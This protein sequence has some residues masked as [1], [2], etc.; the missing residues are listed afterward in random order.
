MSVA[1]RPMRSNFKIAASY[2]FLALLKFIY[3]VGGVQLKIY[4][5]LRISHQQLDLKTLQLLVIDKLFLS[6]ELKLNTNN[7][8]ILR[9]L[10]MNYGIT[11][12][13]MVKLIVLTTIQ[14]VSH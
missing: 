6:I 2:V 5:M 9:A 13:G 11:K 8:I 1:R 7:G 4:F 12:R 14:N 10:L 3:A